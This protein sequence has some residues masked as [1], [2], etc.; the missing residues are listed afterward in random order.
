M[1]RT[2]MMLLCITTAICTL[3]VGCGKTE[4]QKVDENYSKADNLISQQTQIQEIET[5][6]NSEQKTSLELED[7]IYIVDFDTDSSMFHVNESCEGKGT[8][9]VTDG[10]MVLHISLPSKNVVNLFLGLAEDAKKES[11][12]ILQPTIDMVTYSDGITEEVHGFDIPIFVLE[13]EFDLALLGTKGTWYNHKVCVSN[14]VMIENSD[15][16]TENS[17]DSIE[18]IHQAAHVELEDGE[19]RI[20]VTIEGGSGKATVSSPAPL[21]IKEERAYAYIEWSSSYYD[22]MRIG[23]ETYYPV[24]EEGNSVF[25]LPISIFDKKIS[26]IADTTAMGTP[27]EIEYTLIFHFNSIEKE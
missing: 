1:K 21:L 14:P 6:D 13:E 25:E 18:N 8:L 7:G 26:V 24:N 15:I 4:T 10:K 20:D 9:T 3:I 17:S 2:Y 22:Y 5:L 19:Y 11:A 27:H 12:Q 23:N 16:T